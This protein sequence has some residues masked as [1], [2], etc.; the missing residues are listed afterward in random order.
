MLTDE[1]DDARNGLLLRGDLAKAFEHGHFSLQHE[2]GHYS[3][4]AL[5]QAFES[6]DGV[7]L[8]L[9]ENQRMRCDGSSWWESKFPHPELVSP[10]TECFCT[11][12]RS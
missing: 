10:E 12:G 9:D 4:V 8:G 3:V 11:L 1:I 6:L 7:M 2:D 5:S